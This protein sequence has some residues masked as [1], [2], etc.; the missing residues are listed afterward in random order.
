MI[1]QFKNPQTLKLGMVGGTNFGRYPFMSQ[2]QTW[3]MIVVDGFLV[4]YPGYAKKTTI[5]DGGIG[6]GLKTSTRFNH[7][8]CG[9]DSGIFTINTNLNAT[10]VGTLVTEESDISIAENNNNEIAV[11]DGEKI[12]IYNYANGS[13]KTSGTDFDLD[14]IPAYV[15]FHDGRFNA[16][17][18]NKP[19]WRLSREGNGTDWTP[20]PGAT[21]TGTFETKA[22]NVNAVIPIP[23]KQNLIFVI[24]NI[25][26]QAWTDVGRQLFPYV[27]NSATNIDYGCLSAFTIAESDKFVVWL[28]ANEKSGLVIMYSAGGDAQTISTD[29]LNFKFN[30]LINP[31]NSYGF[32]F[33]ISGHLIYQFTFPDNK[34]SYAYD[35]ETGLFFNVSN[36]YQE[37]HIAKRVA[38]FNDK[39][40]FISFEDG[41]LYELGNQYA[42]LDGEE[43]PRIRIPPT[44]RMPNTRPFI[45]TSMDFLIEQGESTT[46]QRV[47]ICLSTDGGNNFGETV[48]YELNQQGDRTNIFSLY[49]LGR[50]NALTSQFRFWGKSRY[51]VG[52][53]TLGV[54][55]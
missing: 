3:N 19:L 48:G 8:I 2:E 40:Y 23:S 25:V 14:F 53:G 55:V 42:T 37:A 27:L 45:A 4:D 52:E 34:I 35:F 9:I 17:V 30:D 28:G 10:R 16:A 32:L 49:N 24:G 44:I 1:N 33:N 38:F 22:D 31:K 54:A 46:D 50:Q 18:K 26:T 12:Y 20:P 36:R 6:R 29:G 5:I 7:M 43:M 47:D 39:Y 51:V 11:C 21:S 41:N 13:F 15:S